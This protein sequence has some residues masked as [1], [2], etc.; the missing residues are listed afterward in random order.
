SR[1]RLQ[2]RR[3]ASRARD[4][5]RRGVGRRQLR[6]TARAA[7]RGDPVRS[8]RRSGPSGA[9]GARPRRDARGRRHPSE[10]DS[11]PRL[12]ASPLSGARAAERH[13]EYSRGRPRALAAR[14][15]NSDT[16]ERPSLPP[17]PGEPG[18]PGPE[19]HP[20]PRRRGPR[21]VAAR[22][23]SLPRRIEMNWS[24]L[25]TAFGLVFL[26]EMGDK[27]QLAVITLTAR[28]EAPVSVFLG[29]SAALVAVTLV[30]AFLGGVV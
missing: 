12:R 13:R 14:A 30:G 26:A 20:H 4:R 29:A 17:P 15:R 22:N 27:T 9:G 16:D 25:A 2:P 6:E 24:A 1:V 3:R 21:P 8:G 5:A 19:Q 10:R 28:T 18:P 11:T 7:R 23:P